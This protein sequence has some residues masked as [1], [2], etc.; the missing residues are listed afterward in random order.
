M[1]CDYVYVRNNTWR[2][3]E[4]YADERAAARRPA[5]CSRYVDGG[6][7]EARKT[8]LHAHSVYGVA[9]LVDDEVRDPTALDNMLRHI[10]DVGNDVWAPDATYDFDVVDAHQHDMW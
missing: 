5:M 6:G 1:G 2:N 10:T 7:G 9:L 8:P 4:C 3:D